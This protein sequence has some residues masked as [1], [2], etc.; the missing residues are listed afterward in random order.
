MI[1]KIALRL[2][3]KVVRNHIRIILFYLYL[4]LI[5]YASEPYTAKVIAITDGDTLKVL[6]TD[7]TQV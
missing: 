1:K 7:K 6:T 2:S 4:P 3:S 5:S